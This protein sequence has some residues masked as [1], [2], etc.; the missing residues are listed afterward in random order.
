M[1]ALPNRALHASATILVLAALWYVPW[2]IAHADLSVAWLSIPFVAANLLLVMAVVLACVNNW[3]KQI[4]QDLLLGSEPKPSVLVLIPTLGEPIE[5]VARTLRSVIDQQWP[6]SSLCVVVGDDSHRSEI[7]TLVHQIAEEYPGALIVYHRPPR[8]G[9]AERR[10]DAKAGNLNSA[11]AVGLLAAPET[12]FVETRD[13]DDMVG[14]RTF[15]RR[16]VAQLVAEPQ[17][18]Y[19]QTIKEA[20]VS[21]H[22]PFDNNQAHFYR[23]MLPARNATNSVFPCGSGVVWRRS[24]LADIGWFPTWNLVEDLESGV[25]ALGRGWR[26]VFLPIVGAIAQHAPEDIPNFYKQRGT[27]ALDTMRLA[28]W[29]KRKGLGLRQRLHFVELDLFYL[30]AIATFIF[31]LAPVCGFLFDQYPLEAGLRDY[32][33]H[34]WPFA[35]AVELFLACL[36][37]PLSY[38]SV[39]RARIIWAGLAPV[40]VK[41]T[42]L[43]LVGGSGRKP[44]YV[45]TRKTHEFG[46][47]WRE[48]G[49]QAGLLLLLFGSMIYS[50]SRKNLLERFDLGTAYWAILYGLLLA[51]FLRLSWFHPER[52]RR[53]PLRRSRSAAMAAG[54]EDRLLDAH[55]PSPARIPVAESPPRHS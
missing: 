10:G 8:Q 15:L 48:T 34:F 23:G 51:A 43:A 40:Y 5:Q 9:A 27:W 19:V 38:E 24:A 20:E 18:A 17:V 28:F 55:P 50:A 3:T 11:V 36:F 14:D 16:V 12:E 47:Y 37:S 25:R 39:W 33:A 31:I 30:Q 44:R 42:F 52:I 41:A 4:P 45:V 32:V 7:A 29:G 22:D 35:I 54:G 6:A 53:R 21:A 13:A 2:L 46:W 1:I 49:V 26:G